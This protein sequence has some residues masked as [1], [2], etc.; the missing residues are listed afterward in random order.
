MKKYV[1]CKVCGFIMEERN[2]KDVCPACGV[3][4]TAFTEHKFS[5][6]EKR[7]EILSL[8]LH[9]ITVHFPEAIA[10]FSLPFLLLSF[11]TF[12]TLSTNLLITTK[13]L[14]IIFPLTVLVAI[15]T[16]IYDG[17]VRFKKLTP[18]YLKAKISIGSILLISST[19]SAILLQTS[20]D[21][22]LLKV[23]LIVLTLNNLVTCVILGKM[24]GQ[25]IDSK[26]PG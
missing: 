5:I 13:I 14:S 3:P 11:I 19:L 8:H 25:L 16:G 4:K 18:P 15:L 2:L 22:I 26:M 6:S 24:G 20:L 1:R 7:Q 9:P 21:S 10:V 17:K 23:I 12:G